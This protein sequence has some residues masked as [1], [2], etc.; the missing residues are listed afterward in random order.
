MLIFPQTF[1]AATEAEKAGM[2]KARFQLVFLK[3]VSFRVE[4]KNDVV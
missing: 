2:C 1:A 3:L 4:F